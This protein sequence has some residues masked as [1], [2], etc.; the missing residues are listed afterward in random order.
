[1]KQI[2]GKRTHSNPVSINK[3]DGSPCESEDEVLLR[4]REHSEQALNHSPGTSSA[5]LDTESS[6]V[7]ADASASTDEPS[8]PEITKAI[9]KLRNGRAPGSDG[10]AVELLKYAITPVAKALHFL[11]TRVWRTGHI[12]ADWKD[13]ILVTL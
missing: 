3:A 5:S 12:P 2:S 6:S 10:I 13:G 4:W 7:T 11:F 8:L 9:T 1:M